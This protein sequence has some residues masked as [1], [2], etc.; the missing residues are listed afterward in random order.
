[1]L[2]KKIHANNFNNPTNDS[3]CKAN[4]QNLTR[5]QPLTRGV[6]GLVPVQ[7]DEGGTPLHGDHSQ[8]RG[9]RA[10]GPRHV[11]R[12]ALLLGEEAEG[13]SDG[14]RLVRLLVRLVDHVRS[15]RP[16][17]HRHRSL[18]GVWRC[19]CVSSV[20]RVVVCGFGVVCWVC[21]MVVCV[22]GC[23]CLCGGVG[24]GFVLS[25][26]CGGCVFDCAVWMQCV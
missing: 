14:T 26:V 20:C 12:P 9:G 13:V 15:C 23:V 7:D 16:G 8:V 3:K 2:K 4:H 19:G 25:V 1:M 6:V 17:E 10:G 24:C 21:V 11:L 22:C 18:R 5:R